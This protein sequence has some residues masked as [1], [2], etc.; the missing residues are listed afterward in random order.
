MITDEYAQRTDLPSHNP[1]LEVTIDTG[2][3]GGVVYIAMLVSAGWGF[4]RRYVQLARAGITVLN[5]Y[6]A[7]VVCTFV[8]YI[9]AWVK[10]GGTAVHLSYFML[11]ALLVLPQ[12]LNDSSLPAS[13][14]RT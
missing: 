4:V 6:F 5:P 1:F 14:T 7:V 9:S 2:L 11:I 10:S 13:F 12:R 8:G 3:F